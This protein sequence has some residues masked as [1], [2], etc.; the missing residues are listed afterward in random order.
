MSNKHLL[1][2]IQRNFIYTY[3]KLFS[4]HPCSSSFTNV[5]YLPLRSFLYFNLQCLPKAN[6]TKPFR[7]CVHTT[8]VW[9]LP[10]PEELCFLAPHSLVYKYS[11]IF[12]VA[13]QISLISPSIWTYLSPFKF[14]L[15]VSFGIKFLEFALWPSLSSNHIC[16]AMWNL[17]HHVQAYITCQCSIQEDMRYTHIGTIFQIIPGLNVKDKFLY[18]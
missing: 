9:C 16:H 14:L 4:K 12:F 2:Y 13:S 11:R 10:A 17:L 5:I 18:T 15:S 3:Q 1:S 8:L 6:R 7:I